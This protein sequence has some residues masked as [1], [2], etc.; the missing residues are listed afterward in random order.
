MD[1]RFQNALWVQNA[2][3]RSDLRQAHRRIRELEEEHERLIEELA[4][5]NGVKIEPVELEPEMGSTQAT[6][7]VIQEAILEQQSW[8]KRY[9][10][11]RDVAQ[12]TD[13]WRVLDALDGVFRTVAVASALQSNLRRIA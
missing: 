11:L 6:A 5:A 8:K 2:S 3:L 9:A 12:L 4:R 1:P 10:E 13:L 7:V